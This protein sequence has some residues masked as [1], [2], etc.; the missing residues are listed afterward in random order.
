[1]AKIARKQ[2]RKAVLDRIDRN[3]RTINGRRFS[4]SKRGFYDEEPADTLRF[5]LRDIWSAEKI[6]TDPAD[7]I[8]TG[9]LVAGTTQSIAI[10]YD[11]IML[12]RDPVY[13]DQAFYVVSGSGFQPGTAS[14]NDASASYFQGD[15]INERFGADYQAILYDAD[16]TLIPASQSDGEELWV[17]DYNTGVLSNLQFNLNQYVLP[18]RLTVYQYV[19]TALDESL[20]LGN[21]DTGS[22]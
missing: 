2:F 19:G 5:H 14:Y 15:F 13:P 20:D 4:T 10:K 6:P 17:F 9:S 7:A 18:L 21:F 16:N 1:M 11:K 3:F 22:C 12:T 8:T